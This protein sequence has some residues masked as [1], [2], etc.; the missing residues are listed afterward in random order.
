MREQQPA[1]ALSG[2]AIG[3]VAVTVFLGGIGGGIAFPILPLLGLRLGLSGLLI[4]FILSANRITRL[5][6]NPVTGAWIDRIGGKRPVVVGLLIEAFSTGTFS[7]AL[8]TPIA[9]WLLLAGRAFWGIGSSLLIIGGVTLALNL[10]NEATR[11]RSTAAVR[12]SMSLGMPAGMLLGGLIAG[13][14]SDD[15]AFL[16]A[17]VSALVAAFVSWILVPD[18][19]PEK[20]EKTPRE[21]P[22]A[23]ASERLKEEL[24]IILSSDRR[25]K[26]VWITNLLIF[27]SIQGT[28]LATLVLLVHHRGLIILHLGVQPTA[29]VLM[30]VMI[31]SSAGVTILVGRA[32]D[33]I[34]SR[35]IL[36]LPAVAAAALGFALLGFGHGLP[37]AI[38]A[39]LA[40]GAGMGGTS[41]PLLTLLGDLTP[42]RY[43]GH[44]VGIYQFFGDIGGSLGPIAGV[45]LSSRIGFEILYAGIA[46]LLCIIAALVLRL[47]VAERSIEERE[48]ARSG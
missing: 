30:A 22:A 15:A 8:H 29:G 32:L 47:R 45:E 41:I 27:F 1:T 44:T 36:S 42:P 21:E 28:L 19:R 13:L 5:G 23:R 38:V 25:V 40:I 35:T 7:L 26:T 3:P 17:T 24:R 18:R 46:G 14:L 9:G 33:R 31:L 20:R 34:R 4:G 39:L 2:K 6:M 16:A 43:R 12:M 37:D 11:G 48:G 10:S